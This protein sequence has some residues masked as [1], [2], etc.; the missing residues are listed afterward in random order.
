MFKV[1]NKIS[2]LS[3][4]LKQFAICAAICFILTAPAFYLLTKYYYAEDMID[5]IKAVSRGEGVPPIDLEQDIVAGMMI[6]Y[7]LIFCVFTIA[8]FITMRFVTKKVWEPFDDTLRK[9]EQFNLAQN[10]I[11]LFA[12][13]DIEEFNRLNLSL[14]RLMKKDR[15]TYRIQK[16]FTEN[17]SHELQTPLAIIR[18]KLD[19]LMQGKL[20]EKELKLVSDLY[21]LTM[22]IGHLNHNLLLLAKIENAQYTTLQEVDVAEM[23]SES[24]PLYEALQNGTTLKLVDENDANTKDI[25]YSYHHHLKVQANPVLLE[26][27]LKN[28]IVNAIRHSPSKGEIQ[29][30]VGNHQLI[31]SNDSID[32]KNGKPLDSKTLF[33]RFRSGDNQQSSPNTPSIEA[34]RQKGNGLGLAIVKAIC[35]FHHWSI[36]YYFEDGKH[37]FIVHFPSC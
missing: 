34:P 13:T 28:L 2:L 30:I 11:P 27:L 33:Q 24:L 31:V 10:N 5:I 3:K 1:Q 20:G 4:T 23:L 37:Q 29:L 21:Q 16:E 18:S 26:C 8:M 32:R 7:L 6:Q 25:G 22:R 17:A 19:L 12:D 35:D 14:E 36:E 9:A 15:E